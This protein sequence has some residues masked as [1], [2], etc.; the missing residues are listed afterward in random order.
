MRVLVLGVTGML[1][2]ALYRYLCQDRDLE[3]WGTLRS[4]RG[5]GYFPEPLQ[6]CLVSGVDVLNLDSLTQ[7]MLRS[8][9]QVVINCVGMIK[10]LAGAD[11]P[12]VALPL[13]SLLPHRLARLCAIAGSRLVHISTDCV[14]SGR[15]G[16]Y[17]EADTSDAQ[18]L[19]GKSKYIG[20]VNHLPHAITLR[21]SII[22]HELN[23]NLALVDWFLSREGE[24]M[25][26]ANALFSGLP[27]IELARV[28]QQY[29]LP[30][31]QLQ[32][33]YQVASEPIDKLALLRLV[34]KEYAK[35]IVIH[36][37]ERVCI[38]RSLDATRFSQASGYVAPQWP[39][40]V[41]RMK[42]SRDNDFM[43]V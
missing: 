13:N 8:K 43:V 33:L 15:R 39:V 22:G 1:G 26:Y 28:I 7:V 38:D 29:V 25:G 20:E 27:T 6:A 21:T 4:D 5:K 35:D 9:P 31:N 34:A 14:F 12:L 41:K 11:D 30:N 24:V 23:S 3:V 36:P 42:H 19:Y 18:D 32:G 2:N 10:Q 37:D 16:G 40:L 17:T